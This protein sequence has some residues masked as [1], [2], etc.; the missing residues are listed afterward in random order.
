[1]IIAITTIMTMAT[2]VIFEVEV[3]VLKQVHLSG[4]LGCTPQPAFLVGGFGG[5]VDLLRDGEPGAHQRER[6][7]ERE[8]ER[9]REIYIYICMHSRWIDR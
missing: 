3:D 6:E 1:M 7:R 4:L 9:E 8:T 5:L 2:I